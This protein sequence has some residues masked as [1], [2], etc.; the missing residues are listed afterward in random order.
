MLGTAT[1][2]SAGTTSAVAAAKAVSEDQAMRPRVN[3]VCPP[4]QLPSGA[5]LV[6]FILK[7]ILVSQKIKILRRAALEKMGEERSNQYRTVLNKIDKLTEFRNTL[8]HGAFIEDHEK[9]DLH[10]KLGRSLT[11]F[12]KGFEVIDYVRVQKEGETVDALAGELIA[13]LL[14]CDF[15][16]NSSKSLEQS[17]SGDQ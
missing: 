10:G 6:F 17:G 12:D 9:G 3:F 8:V 15:K 16:P 7:D 13:A 14:V 11:E 2:P 4:H 1:A 5:R